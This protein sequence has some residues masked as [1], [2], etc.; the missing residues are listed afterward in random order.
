M[1]KDEDVN[2]IYCAH[3]D[4]NKKLKLT[5]WAC[6]CKKIYCYKHRSPELHNCIYDFKEINKKE[7]QIENMKCNSIKL[8]TK[9]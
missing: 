5:D 7:K 8:E 3:I 9:V 2:N 6:K 4:C 1:E